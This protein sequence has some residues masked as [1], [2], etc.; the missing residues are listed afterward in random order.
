MPDKLFDGLPGHHSIVPYIPAN[1]E[2]YMN[3][4]QQAHF[5]EILRGWRQAL[6]EE[7]DRTV[8]HMKDETVLHADPNDRATQEADIGLELQTRERERR[9]LPKIDKALHQIDEHDYGYCRKCGVEI[10]IRRL[11]ARPTADLCINCK[12]LAE[13]HE[14][15]FA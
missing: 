7:V 13:A 2:E 9:L 3:E 8:G 1:G 6:M 10:G 14:K 4:R 15:R 11:E 12:T 5:R